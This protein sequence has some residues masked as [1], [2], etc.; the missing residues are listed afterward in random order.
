MIWL[1]VV[2][3]SFQA[4]TLCSE[5]KPNGAPV[6]VYRR[7]IKKSQWLAFSDKDLMNGFINGLRDD[8]KNHVISNQP[9][10]FTEAENLARLR[11]AVSR[12]SGL[13]NQLPAPQSMLQEQRIKELEH[14]VNLLVSLA[15]QNKGNMVPP[16][17]TFDQKQSRTT[18]SSMQPATK[19]AV[20]AP[21]TP[22]NINAIKN[23][24]IAAIQSGFQKNHTGKR[25]HQIQPFMGNQG[26]A[27]GRYLRTTDGQPMCTFCSGTLHAIVVNAPSS[28]PVMQLHRLNHLFTPGLLHRTMQEGLFD[29]SSNQMRAPKI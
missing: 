19:S 10:S 14:H 3:I 28:R 22:G 24:I 2:G 4:G 7:H 26:G 25:P 6:F 12:N 8:V 29:P 20:D 9:K 1:P 15:G 23:E 5:T 11:E 13:S 27:H 17:S 16:V 21:V 18:N